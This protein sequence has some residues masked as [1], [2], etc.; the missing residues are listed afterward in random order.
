VYDD[1]EPDGPEQPERSTDPQIPAA[2]RELEA[3]IDSKPDDVFYSRQLEVFLE[4]RFFDWITNRALREMIEDRVV[5]HERREAKC[6]PEIL[7]VWNRKNRYNRRRAKRVISLVEQYS[8]PEFGALLGH[9]GQLLFEN[10]MGRSNFRLLAENVNEWNGRKWE[11]SNED[12]D[13]IY[14]RDGVVYGVEVK[15]AL[16]RMKETELISKTAM[17]EHLGVVPFFV[18]RWMPQNWI[19]R[20]AKDHKGF[21]LMLK[22]Q[23]Y[24]ISHASFAR[25]IREELGLPVDAPP[26][27]HPKTLERI[28][29]AHEKRVNSL[30]NSQ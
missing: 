10:A 28:V 24:P 26:R 4:D 9:Q 8:D 1:W 22:W 23:L 30:R 11:K 15:N 7:L 14:E 19:Q 6:P 17:C 18:V 5:E 12:L 3:I 25:T 29:K 21:V 13:Y 2:R 27:Y 20:T 16:G